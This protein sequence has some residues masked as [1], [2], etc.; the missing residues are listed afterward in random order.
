MIR[1]YNCYIENNT[2]CIETSISET[3][4]SSVIFYID[5]LSNINNVHETEED[6]HCKVVN[7]GSYT[8]ETTGSKQVIKI[9]I[10]ELEVNE[11]VVTIKESTDS[12][13]LAYDITKMNDALYK[14]LTVFCSTC[15]DKLQKTRIASALFR[16]ILIQQAYDLDNI[17]DAVKAYNDLDRI[18]NISNSC[19]TACISNSA[20]KTC[21]NGVCSL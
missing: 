15:I 13:Y 1:K 8:K 2:L 16:Y 18:L 4:S 7:S 17:E 11:V 12:H 21:S 19:T 20:C 5:K 9:D 10:S 3:I 14:L 6:K